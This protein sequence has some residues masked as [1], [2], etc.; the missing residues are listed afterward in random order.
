MYVCVWC[1]KCLVNVLRRVQFET[2]S[3]VS[4][5]WLSFSHSLSLF[6]SFAYVREVAKLTNASLP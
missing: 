1:E 6:S 5:C 3:Y 2:Y 4:N